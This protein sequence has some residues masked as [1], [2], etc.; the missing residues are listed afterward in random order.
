M[1]EGSI[2]T[3]LVKHSEVLGEVPRFDEYQLATLR[4]KE[5]N[6][7]E[8]Q[9]VSLWRELFI[10]KRALSKGVNNIVLW[11][12]L[13]RSDP[14]YS[15][16][17]IFEEPIA[18]VID[19]DGENKPSKIKPALL[20]AYVRSYSH[21]PERFASVIGLLPDVEP[22]IKEFR[23][24]VSLEDGQAERRQIIASF[25]GENFSSVF[26]GSK[27][28]PDNLWRI[29]GSGVYGN[30]RGVLQLD[31]IRAVCWGVGAQVDIRSLGSPANADSYEIKHAIL[32][33]KI[34]GKSSNGIGDEKGFWVEGKR[35]ALF[36]ALELGL[37][38]AGK[39]A[40]HLGYANEDL[41]TL[42]AEAAQSSQNLLARARR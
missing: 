38:L 1:R 17:K 30:P 37:K 24:T 32:D 21:G 9:D 25:R 41:Q 20:N 31:A 6:R 27:Q 15:K 10:P 36:L 2:V 18:I 22:W 19:Q 29:T 5:R 14:S 12:R 3:V 39:T 7:T 13:K 11:S 8:K 40:A 42:R 4:W 16:P 34:F 26:T 33:G 23:R 28:W 35:L